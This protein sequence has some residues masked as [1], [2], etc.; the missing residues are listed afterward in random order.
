MDGKTV[1]IPVTNLKI[2]A[3]GLMN[4]VRLNVGE[5][6]EGIQRIMKDSN[7]SDRLFSLQSKNEDV[8]RSLLIQRLASYGK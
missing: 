3:C 6:A 4:T 1:T 8:L 5:Y 2:P 7:H